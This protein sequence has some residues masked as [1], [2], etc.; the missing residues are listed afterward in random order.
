MVIKIGKAILVGILALLWVCG[1]AAWGHPDEV[2]TL[3]IHH[4]Y[5]EPARRGDDT[6]V[7]LA[8]ENNGASMR[9]FM[10]LHIDVAEASQIEVKV[11]AERFVPITSIAIPPGELLDLRDGARIRLLALNRTLIAGESLEALLDFADGREKRIQVLV[12]QGKAGH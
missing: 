9:Q 5:A 2:G 8:I 12:G 1:D 7:R 6:L 11:E 10:G 4:A 3:T